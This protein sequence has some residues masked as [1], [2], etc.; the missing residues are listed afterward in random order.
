M[1]NKTPRTCNAG[2]CYVSY[3]IVITIV[4]YLWYLYSVVEKNV[5][6]EIKKSEKNP[7][8]RVLFTCIQSIRGI[9]QRFLICQLLLQSDNGE[10]MP[11]LLVAI[12]RSGSCYPLGVAAAVVGQGGCRLTA[13]EPLKPRIFVVILYWTVSQHLPLNPIRTFISMYCHQNWISQI[14]QTIFPTA[15]KLVLLFFIVFCRTG[16]I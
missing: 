12:S 11:L 16:H 14:S 9:Q 1:C 5:L 2:D 10:M 4:S 13:F 3:G 8:S 15:P 6:R 7:S